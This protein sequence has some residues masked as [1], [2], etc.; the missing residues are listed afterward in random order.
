MF[1]YQNTLVPWI[2]VKQR[3]ICDIHF[4]WHHVNVLEVKMQSKEIR[5]LF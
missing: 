3:I 5:V 2:L 4:Y 1:N